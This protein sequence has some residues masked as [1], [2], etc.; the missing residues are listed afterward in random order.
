MVDQLRDLSDERL[1]GGCVF[2]DSKVE[3]TRDHVPSRVLL[4]RPYPENLPVVPACQPCNNGFSLDEQ[5]VACLVDCVAAGATD[6]QKVQREQVRKI[7][8]Q[9]PKLRERLEGARL[10]GGGSTSFVP[11]VERV[12]NVVL[13]LARGHAAFELGTPQRRAPDS[14]W[15]AVLGGMEDADAEPFL[16]PY[17][18]QLLGEVG[19]R[20]TQRMAVLEATLV[21]STGEL[22]RAPLICTLWVEVQAGRYRYQA[23]ED[24]DGVTIRMVL[25][26]Y[27]ACEVRWL[28]DTE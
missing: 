2:C 8:E 16:M 1:R 4:D 6:P 17:V 23:V 25:S 27:L 26:E 21:S 9:N 18:H 28:A 10:E 11:E 22:V 7:L 19:S 20:A 15:W 12:R 24:R 5:Y 13:K 3:D 14:L